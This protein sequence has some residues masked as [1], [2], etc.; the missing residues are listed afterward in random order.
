[1]YVTAANS[2]QVFDKRGKHLGNIP[3]SRS[4][5][6]I[7]ISGAQRKTLYAV[8]AANVNAERKVWIESIPLLATGPKG[9]G[10]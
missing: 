1:L 10:K 2:V 5:V 7:A 4:L 9:R 8:T 3:A 6:S